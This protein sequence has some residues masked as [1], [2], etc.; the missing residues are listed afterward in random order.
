MQIE[1]TKWLRKATTEQKTH[2]YYSLKPHFRLFDVSFVLSGSM[3][4][5]LKRIIYIFACAI[6]LKQLYTM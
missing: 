1:I 6:A 4:C 2:L 3:N 5:E